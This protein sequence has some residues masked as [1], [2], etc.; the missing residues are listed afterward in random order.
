MIDTGSRN[1]T[2]SAN[3][4]RLALKLVSKQSRKAVRPFALT[5]KRLVKKA[6][7]RTIQGHTGEAQDKAR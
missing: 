5:W 2:V 4:A 3:G 1:S 7:W 6:A